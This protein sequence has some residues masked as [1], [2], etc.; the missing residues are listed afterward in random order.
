[1]AI[2]GRIGVSA[3]VFSLAASF[4]GVA[5]AGQPGDGQ[6]R[7]WQMGLQPAASTT[8]ERMVDFHNL[9]L[10]V[11]T[12]IT[13]FVLLLLLYVM[14][15]FSEKRN[16]TPSKTTHNTVIEVLWTTVPVIILVLIA[17][18]SF[19]LLYYADRVEDA[20]MTIKAIGHQ[21]YWSY[22]YPDHGDFTFDGFML[23]D[24]EREEGQPRLLATDTFVVLPVDTKIRLLV[25]ADDVLH[26]FAMPAFGI[27][28]DANPG[29]INETW[30][31]IT[32]EGTYYGQCSEI[33]G[34]GHTYMPI[35]IKAVSKEAFDEWTE[36]AKIEYARAGAP[37][38]DAPEEKSR[39]AQVQGTE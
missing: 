20:D 6:P 17:I 33:C 36:Q 39:L 30:M 29:M 11:T 5:G 7:D 1:M 12:L 34:A 13:G 16:P 38:A 3:G 35:A 4:A 10:V 18:P 31:E 32:R 28:L 19:K 37:E 9:L 15:R 22:E 23:S 21:W 14:Y 27:K 2:F 24:D 8:M 26:S 25:T